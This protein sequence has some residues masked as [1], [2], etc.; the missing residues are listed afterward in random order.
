[1]TKRK[2]RETEPASVLAEGEQPPVEPEGKGRKAKEPVVTGPVNLTRYTA[3]VV[4]NMAEV[5]TLLQLL[6]SVPLQGTADQLEGVLPV[7]R[8]LKG[9]LLQAAQIISKKLPVS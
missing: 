5:Q 9:K 7:Y 1:M 6:N 8:S 3:P 4:L 2:K